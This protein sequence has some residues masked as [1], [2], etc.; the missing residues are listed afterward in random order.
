MVPER[1]PHAPVRSRPCG[2]RRPGPGRWVPPRRG[3]C[4]QA[5]V[6]HAGLV[7]LVLVVLT[8]AVAVAAEVRGEGIVNAVNSGV[9]RAICVAGGD[10]CADFHVQRPCAVAVDERGTSKG[11]SLGIWRV[12]KDRSV[13]VERRSDGTVVVTEYDDVEGGAGLSAGLRFG[14]G[15]VTSDDEGEER[16]T[17]GVTATAG[18]EGRLRGG[19]GRSWE[20][21]EGPAARE[22]VRRLQAGEPVRR[23]DVDR[24]RIGA[25][26][27]GSVEASGPLGIDATGSVLAGW[28]GEG[29]RDRRTGETTASLAISRAVAGDLSGPLG[30]R[31]GGALEL[32]PSVTVVTDGR[33][34]GRELR[35]AGRLTTREGTQ[36]RD[37][38][39]RIDM[40]RPQV[41]DGIGGVLRGLVRGDLGGSAAAAAT[42]G[43]WAVDEGW[44]DEREYRTTS[45]TDGTDLEVALG[46]KLGFRDQETASTERLVS[47]HTSPPGGLREDRTDCVGAR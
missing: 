20:L 37:V 35:L 28:A 17:G 12:G 11:V 40:T 44:V 14:K 13:A 25:S 29:T 43:R 2:P 1:R 27:T 23:P 26:A 34:R 36:R 6:E 46:L 32:E 18:F 9:R 45:T 47:A 7:A 38:Q 39:I 31:L 10:D 30:L 5:T 15:R 16:K 41:R 4:G 21:P 19:W 42:L 24:V 3:E 8:A 33:L 22:L